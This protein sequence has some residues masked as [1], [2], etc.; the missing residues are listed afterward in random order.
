MMD[1]RTY[2][3]HMATSNT[4]DAQPKEAG[5]VNSASTLQKGDGLTMNLQITVLWDTRRAHTRTRVQ[6]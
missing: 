5:S 3:R 2:N 1:D 6:G 4:R